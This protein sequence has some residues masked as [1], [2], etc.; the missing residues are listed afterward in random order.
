VALALYRACRAEWEDAVAAAAAADAMAASDAYMQMQ[1]PQGGGGAAAHLALAYALASPP[2]Q[3]QQQHQ[4]Q[5]QQYQHQQLQQLEGDGPPLSPAALQPASAGSRGVPNLHAAP[6]VPAVRLAASPPLGASPSSPAA[7]PL[8]DSVLLMPLHRQPPQ[9]QAPPSAASLALQLSP[10]H[11]HQLPL[12]LPTSPAR[13]D[14]GALLGAR[15]PEAARAR[16]ARGLP[17]SLP[18]RDLSLE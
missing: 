15:G 9:L 11:P 3:Q 17:V 6:F 16:A 7:S 10:P 2:Q 18:P 4:Q 1:F 14:A 12:P 8:A 13:L 5:H